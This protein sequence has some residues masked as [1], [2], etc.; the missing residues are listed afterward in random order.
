AWLGVFAH[1]Q[2]VHLVAGEYEILPEN[3]L[4]GTPARPVEVKP[5][6]NTTIALE[7]PTRPVAPAAEH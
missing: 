3:A 7:A 6:Q 2:T 4:K 1:N 5:L